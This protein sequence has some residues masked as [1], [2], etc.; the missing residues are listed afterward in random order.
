MA[1]LIAALHEAGHGA[2]LLAT[3][4]EIEFMEAHDDGHGRTVPVIRREPSRVSA[5]AAVAQL[6]AAAVVSAAGAAATARLVPARL[7]A[8]MPDQSAGDDLALA[9]LASMCDELTG[10]GDPAAWIA[11]RREDAAAIVAAYASGIWRV[12]DALADTG[13]LSGAEAAALLVG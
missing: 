3:G 12:A 5:G 13:R 4:Q 6:C 9:E 10:G 1:S 11:R 2:A 7:A 8:R